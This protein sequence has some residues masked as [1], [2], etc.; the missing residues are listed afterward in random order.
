MRL[1]LLWYKY[2]LWLYDLNLDSLAPES[3]FLITALYCPSVSCD[4]LPA[5][6]WNDSSLVGM[7]NPGLE[8]HLLLLQ[9]VYQ[10]LHTNIFCEY[11]KG[12]YKLCKG[13]WMLPP[14]WRPYLFTWTCIFIPVLK[15]LCLSLYPC[16]LICLEDRVARCLK[17]YPLLSQLWMNGC[18]NEW[19]VSFLFLPAYSTCTLCAHHSLSFS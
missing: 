3:V 19:I 11:R 13:I 15:G 10:T 14:D 17:L 2:V 5:I 1:E 7:C 8:W 6:T 18:I 16:R 9:H 12:S 4:L